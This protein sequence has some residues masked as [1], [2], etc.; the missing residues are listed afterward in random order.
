MACQ[1]NA[2]AAALLGFL[3]ERPMSGW[4]LLATARELIGDFWTVTRSQV[5]RELTAMETAGLVVAGPPGPRERRPFEIT[6]SGRAAFAEWLRRPP[7]S[8]QIR[9]PLLLTIAFGHHLP[10]G[11]LPKFVAEHREIHEQ[12]LARYRALWVELGDDPGPYAVATLDFGLR[13]ESAV[14][15]WFDHLPPEI[16]GS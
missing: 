12:R 16:A 15:D 7:G 8:E 3:H 1:V 11:E 4:D 9:Y 2:T 14:L 10:P 5:Y 6:E 13:Y